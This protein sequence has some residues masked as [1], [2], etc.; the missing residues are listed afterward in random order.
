MEN[1]NKCTI[2]R[3]FPDSVVADDIRYD[4]GRARQF[5]CGIDSQRGQ[6]F[7]VDENRYVAD[8]I[9]L[10]RKASKSPNW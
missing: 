10:G 7:F 5:N 2:I 9:R 4:R 8:D 3:R 6:L 1:R